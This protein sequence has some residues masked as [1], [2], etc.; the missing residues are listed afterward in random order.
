MITM[1]T[2][3]QAGGIPYGTPGCTGGYPTEERKQAD[4]RKGFCPSCGKFVALRA[5]GGTRQHLP[6]ENKTSATNRSVS[7]Q[8][9]KAA[10]WSP[11]FFELM[12]D[13]FGTRGN[14]PVHGACRLVME[15]LKIIFPEGEKM[16]TILDR[17][18]S[19]QMVEY[20][21]THL[22]LVQHY[23]L[24]VGN[25][26]LDGNGAHTAYDVTT[27]EELG[28]FKEIPNLLVPATPELIEWN[29]GIACPYGAPEKAAE[30]IR[31]YVA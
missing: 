27:D 18:D 3:K 21:K 1:A 23:V 24:K 15:A 30:Y 5:N 11:G 12:A 19:P 9:I 7:P 31:S 22:P 13:V 26:Y 29:R 28:A 14:D 10:C 8:Q 16:A 4:G 17:G 25:E 20:F 2:V 6:Q